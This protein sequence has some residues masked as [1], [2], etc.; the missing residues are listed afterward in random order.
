MLHKRV[1]AHVGPMRMGDEKCG[2]APSLFLALTTEALPTALPSLRRPYIG[3][4][5]ASSEGE[6]FAKYAAVVHRAFFEL[7]Q[8]Y[9]GVE[10]HL[11]FAVIVP[12]AE[13]RTKLV[14]ALK[15]DRDVLR[16]KYCADRTV[17]MF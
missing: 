1:V 17:R 15:H 8:A 16:S 14:A 9:P 6:L 13:F 2:A 12:S 7:T 4:F 11:N 3:P 5:E 10:I